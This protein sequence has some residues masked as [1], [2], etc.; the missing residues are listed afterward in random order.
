MSIFLGCDIAKNIQLLERT[1]EKINQALYTFRNLQSQVNENKDHYLHFQF[2][3]FSSIAVNKI[4][5]D[6]NF[7]K[8]RSSFAFCCLTDRLRNKIFVEQMLIYK[9]NEHTKIGAEKITFP[10]KPDIQ[11]YIQTEGHQR[12]QSSFANKNN[13]PLSQ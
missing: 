10:P 2:K 9:R 11:T 12:L 6:D 13:A 3:R 4:N 8:Q 5:K 7:Q 1:Q